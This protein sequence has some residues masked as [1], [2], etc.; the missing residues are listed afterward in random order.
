LLLLHELLRA[1]CNAALS[2][3]VFYLLDRF[4]MRE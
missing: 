3:P 2:V 1:V 4:R